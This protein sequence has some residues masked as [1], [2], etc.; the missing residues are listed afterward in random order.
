MCILIYLFSRKLFNQ[1]VALFA[2]FWSGI[3]V[4]YLRY[5]PRLL[6]E[7]LVFFL[8]VAFF[9]GLYIYLVEKPG[10]AR[11]LAAA[12]LIFVILI[13]TD[14]RY[15]FYLPFLAVF[16]VVYQP[17]WPGMRKYILFLILTL[18]LMAPWTIRNFKAYGGFILIN[19]RTL[20]LRSADSRNRAEHGNRINLKIF[21]TGKRTS[22]SNKDYP[23]ETERQLIKQGLNPNGRTSQEIQAIK[24]D[25]YPTTSFLANKWYQ[26]REFWRPIRLKAEYRP[27][28]DCRFAYWSLKHNLSS[29]L[30]YGLLLP[31]MFYAMVD[32][33]RRKYRYL[34]FLLFPLVIQN[35]LHVLQWALTRYRVPVDA[36]IIMLAGYGIVR[37]YEKLTRKPVAPW[38]LPDERTT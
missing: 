35:L 11:A 8:V 5:V 1:K 16:F 24:D 3:Y 6:R 32:L 36:F 2:F 33:G 37:L 9:Y 12:S 7:T 29:L 18:A 23:T 38:K 21:R 17:F 4:F 10:S 22:T 28:P 25:V 26:M 34:L 20:D 15:L 14:P 19:T 30:C 13:H 27:F 31:F